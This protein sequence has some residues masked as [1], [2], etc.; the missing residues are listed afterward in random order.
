MSRARMRART[1][2]G[3]SPLSVTVPPGMTMTGAVKNHLGTVVKYE[4]ADVRVPIPEAKL[5]AVRPKLSADGIWGIDYGGA[6][7]PFHDG[8]GF[9]IRFTTSKTEAE[10]TTFLAGIQAALA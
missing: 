8:R 3:V 1:R 2:T 7:F 5:A 6:V 4:T 9:R 10:V